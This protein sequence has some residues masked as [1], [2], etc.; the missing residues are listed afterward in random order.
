MIPPFYCLFAF[1]LYILYSNRRG[2]IVGSP[3]LKLRLFAWTCVESNGLKQVTPTCAR[4]G[5]TAVHSSLFGDGLMFVCT[6]GGDH[7]LN[8]CSF[9][10]FRTEREQAKSEFCPDV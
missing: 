8:R 6:E 9:D 4:H 3:M 5:L 1:L 2:S 7:V 10:Q